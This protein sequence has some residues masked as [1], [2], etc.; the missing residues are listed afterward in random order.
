MTELGDREPFT[1]REGEIIRAIRAGFA[2]P[3]SIQ[4]LNTRATTACG[5]VALID[6][7]VNRMDIKLALLTLVQQ[8]MMTQR[9]YIVLWCRFAKDKTKTA[10]AKHLHIDR[11]TVANDE[12]YGLQ[13][14]ARYIWADPAYTTPPRIRQPRVEEAS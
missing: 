13:T 4:S 3:D 12:F 6:R 11:E 7:L 10:T 9:Q 2:P 1:S 5:G 8:N 14:M